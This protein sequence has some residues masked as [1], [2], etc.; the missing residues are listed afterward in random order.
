MEG[1]Y[2]GHVREGKM[3]GVG[4]CVYTDG[5]RYQG[6][7]RAGLKNGRGTHSLRLGRPVRGRVGEWVDA[8]LEGLHLELWKIG[9]K[10]IGDVSYGLRSAVLQG[11]LW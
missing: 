5:S 7:W 6:D 9:D 10:Y 11:M 1:E 4:L 2:T 3:H 8:R